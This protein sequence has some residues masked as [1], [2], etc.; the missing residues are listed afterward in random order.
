MKHKKLLV[1]IALLFPGLGGLH[2]QESVA[3]SGGEASGSGGTASYSIGQIVY[4][5]NSG[6]NGSVGQ[7]VQQPFEI[8]TTVG[9]ELTEINL[10][11]S[12]YPNPAKDYLTLNIGNYEEENL[13]FQ[14]YNVEGKLIETD[15]IFSSETMINMEQL[16]SDTYLLNILENNTLIKTFKI[17]K[18]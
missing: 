7:G 8:I 11:L 15:Q 6:T 9:T 14:L 1:G 13:S 10:E 12:A 2:A 16:S 4:T 17:I 5:T 18:N 3:T